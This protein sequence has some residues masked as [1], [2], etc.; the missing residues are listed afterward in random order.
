MGALM[1]ARRRVAEAL[2]AAL[3]LTLAIP[4]SA[5]WNDDWS[6]RKRI[7]LDVGVL[8]IAEPLADVP[9]LVRLHLGNFSYFGDVQPTGAD[10]RAVATDDLTP[11][12]FHIESFDAVTQIALLWVLLPQITPGL[13]DQGFYLYY[14]NAEAVSG[15]DRPGTFDKLYSAV[16]HF[17]ASGPL[18][19]ATAYGNRLLAQN[20][21]FDPTGL[22]GQGVR[23]N[24]S[25][26]LEVSGASALAARASQGWSVDFWMNLE[27]PQQGVLFDAS[28]PVTGGGFQLRLD[29]TTPVVSLPGETG[30]ELRANPG[31]QLGRWQ[32][33]ALRSRLTGTT[34]LLDGQVV[35]QLPANLA[36][37]AGALRVG[38]GL[39]GDNA[40]NG[41]RLDEL[42]L[43]TSA[44]SDARFLMQAG[45]EPMDG[46]GLLYGEDSQNES[47]AGHEGHFVTTLRNVDW[48]G[49]EGIVVVLC[50][51]IALITW[52]LMAVKG[53][54]IGG[55]RKANIAFLDRY[56]V[57]DDPVAVGGAN[58]LVGRGSTIYELYAL[59]MEEIDR[60]RPVDDPSAPL[61]LSSESVAAIRATMTG[62]NVRISQ[63]L[64]AFMVLLTL[65]I[66]GGPFLGLLGTVVGVM[67][68]FAGIAASGDVNI[69]AI[70]PGIAAA[71]V[72]TVAGLIVAIPALFGYNYISSRIKEVITENNVFLEEFIATVTETYSAGAAHDAG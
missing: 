71:L 62:Q 8:G 18:N 1:S 46:A 37:P 27:L 25:S 45:T 31:L 57:A 10:F 54:F 36:P 21:S 14:G 67:V 24:G 51:I 66:A 15:Q 48:S 4:A 40:L 69:N 56:R 50:V 20:A 53:W 3:L 29:G 41:V 23:F 70:A 28:D 26:W 72:A 30:T 43:S 7:D 5:W 42:R 34:L 17:D 68:T 13:P 47:D 58:G 61:A 38:A 12:K 32:H 11:L 52:Y 16:Y 2:T 63:R 65:A 35:G 64:N 9:V 6:Y 19:D 59:G 39:S 22:I 60:R 55:V 49:L 44:R 33:V